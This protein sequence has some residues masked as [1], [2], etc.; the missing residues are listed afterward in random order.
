VRALVTGGGGFL[1]R[2]IVER[3]LQR[4]YQVRSYSRGHYPELD[5]LGVETARGDLEDATTTAA[6]CAGCDV[7]IHTAALIPNTPGSPRRF[8]AVNV[9][10]T[11]AIIA[12]C[13]AHG[14]GRLAFTSSPSVVFAGTDLCGVDE[15]VPYPDRYDSPYSRT[16]ALA[17]RAVLAANDRNLATVAL[18]PHLV[19]GPGDVHLVPQLVARARQ[20]RLFKIGSG[21]HRIDVTYIDCAAEAHLLAVERLAPGA[22]PAGRAYFISQGEPVNLWQF[23][24]RLLDLAGAPPVTRRLPRWLALTAAGLMEGLFRVVRPNGVPP[25]TRFLVREISSSHWF[26]I[27]AARRD[28][29]Y[30]PPVTIDEGLER[31][32][33]SW[34][35]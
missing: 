27:S 3:L 2:A 24:N 17:E 22:P 10:G 12:G 18:R 25:L 8:Q 30:V 19:W 34:A 28:L 15:S 16:K 21:E 35:N 14:V 29:G 6:A 20:G 32:A 33:R 7:V 5:E 11:E 4:G 1:G 31:L 13:R 23:V 9:A 26:D